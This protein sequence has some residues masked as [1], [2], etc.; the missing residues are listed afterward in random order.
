MSTLLVMDLTQTGCRF[1]ARLLSHTLGSLAALPAFAPFPAAA[2]FA[3]LPCA[4]FD[5][6]PAALPALPAAVP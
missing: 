6:L 2:C 5:L 1:C 4:A 3:G